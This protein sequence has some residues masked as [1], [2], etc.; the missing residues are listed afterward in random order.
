LSIVFLLQALSG[1]VVDLI[2]Q[3]ASERFR[4]GLGDVS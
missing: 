4:W 2:I 1:H 3:L